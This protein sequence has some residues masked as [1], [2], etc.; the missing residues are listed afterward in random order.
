M[1]ERLNST[2]PDK[3]LDREGEGRALATLIDELDAL[4]AAPAGE[5]SGE[6]LVAALARASRQPSL[7]SGAQ[8]RGRPES[9]VRHLLHADPAGRYTLVAIVWEPGQ[10]SPVHGHHTWCGYGVV[11]GD[12]VETSYDEPDDRG[13]VRQD[14][15]VKRA[16]GS[17]FFA[18]AGLADIHRLGNASSRSAVSIHAYGVDGARV[19]SHVNLLVPVAAD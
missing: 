6:P 10:F 13:A 17:A 4:C 3:A 1:K 16:R 19:G 8:C 12:L 5:P 18:R 9:Y 14:G 2:A 7:L 11:A 15:S